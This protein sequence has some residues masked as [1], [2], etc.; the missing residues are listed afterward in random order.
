MQINVKN[1]IEQAGLSEPFYPGK[2]VIKACPQPGEYRSHC[3]V[4]DWHEPSRIRI[5][6]KAGLSGKDLSPKDLVRYP[7]SFQAPT[8]M[9]IDV[10][11]G[12]LRTVDPAANE[13]SED[14][15]DGDGETRS[16]K[17]GSGGRKIGKKLTTSLRSFASAAEGMVPEKGTIV[18][19]VVLGMEIAKEAYGQVLDK[20]F[21]QVGHAKMA[22]TD[23]M[24]AAGKLLTRYTPPA[25]MEP[26]GNEDKVYKYNRE[27]NEMMFNSGMMPT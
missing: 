14:D 19:M 1:F 4:Y 24:A 2:R 26:K 11:T 16:G 8:F 27:K 22:A 7:I 6:I 13:N 25:F 20:F 3:V 9:E 18:T 5:E 23:L 21:D 12:I 10:E 15:E 17:S